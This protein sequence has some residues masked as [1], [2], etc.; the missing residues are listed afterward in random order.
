[1]QI[2][3]LDNA[4]RL[5][6]SKEDLQNP[7]QS[8]TFLNLAQMPPNIA[9]LVRKLSDIC[10]NNNISTILPLSDIINPANTIWDAVKSQSLN[11]TKAQSIPT[12]PSSTPQPVQTIPWRSTRSTQSVP[13]SLSTTIGKLLPNPMSSTTQSPSITTI[14]TTTGKLLPNPMV[15]NTQVSTTTG[16]LISNPVVSTLIASKKKLTPSMYLYP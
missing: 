13:Q 1:M 5:I 11:P 9:I 3:G 12:S 2:Y 10:Q 4:E 6:F 7:L 15:S 16:N 14:A 8:Q